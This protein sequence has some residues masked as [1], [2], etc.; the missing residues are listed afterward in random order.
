[1]YFWDLDALKRSLVE[2]TVPPLDRLGYLASAV[3]ANAIG[4]AMPVV[5]PSLATPLD[6]VIG[7]VAFS[8]GTGIA[9]TANGGRAGPDFLGRYLAL[10]CVAGARFSNF[11][12]L[13]V[14]LLAALAAY[15]W[16]LPRVATSAVGALLYVA[17]YAV[18]AAHLRA[19]GGAPEDRAALVLP[20]RPDE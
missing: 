1:V 14:M 13:P 7:L 15:A 9:F 2:G 10:W 4:A 19:L 20:V 18:L 8:V 6:A 11:V 17:F 12:G 5:S 3:A 16:R